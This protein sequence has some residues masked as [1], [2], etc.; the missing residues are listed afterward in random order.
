MPT[1]QLSPEQVS[2][3]IDQLLKAR[4]PA[5]V[6]LSRILKR[7][8]EETG[9]FPL[10]PLTFEQFQEQGAP[11][12]GRKRTTIFNENEVAV[13]ELEKKVN[14]LRAQLE[15]DRAKSRLAVEEAYRKGVAEGESAGRAAGMGEARKE[16]DDRIARMEQRVAAVLG[17][18]KRAE[19]EFT[20][21]AE[22][23][24]LDLSLHLA[25]KIVDTELTIQP[26]IV[27]R[28][29][30]KA[31]AF[32]SEREK[33]VLRVS[34]GDFETV[35][36]KKE[37]WASI[38]QRLDDIEIISDGRIEQGGCIVESVSGVA[39]ARTGVMLEQLRETIMKTWESMV[40]SE[41]QARPET[42]RP[43]NGTATGSAPDSG[44]KQAAVIK[45]PHSTQSQ[46]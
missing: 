31:L 15:R 41:G 13:L 24:V 16:F 22:K 43:A 40:M 23:A 1:P 29:I 34:P 3:L 14:E 25:R 35:T 33:L 28:V 32:I 17:E 12:A 30:K 27:L 26:D 45:P 2:T 9:A 19:A 11:D 8:S 46:E 39:D 21:S 10:K 42:A 44:E 5:S 37:F 7:K 6:G 36:G 4:D 20:L 38:S 18:T